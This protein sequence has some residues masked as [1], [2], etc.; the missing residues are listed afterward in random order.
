MDVKGLQEIY[1][2]YG[3]SSVEFYDYVKGFVIFLINRYAPCI[4]NKEAMEDLIQECFRKITESMRYYEPKYSNVA[5]F[6]YTSVRNLLSNQRIVK[7]I[8]LQNNSYGIF[9]D[10]TREEKGCRETI[11]D[12]KFSY[13]YFTKTL[14]RLRLNDSPELSNVNDPIVLLFYDYHCK[15]D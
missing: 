2:N 9:Y 8:R 14:K 11:Q 13:F 1:E 7:E 6:L 4:N 15:G 12:E 3:S 10:L 5:S